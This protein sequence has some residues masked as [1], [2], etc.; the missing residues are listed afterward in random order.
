MQHPDTLRQAGWGITNDLTLVQALVKDDLGHRSAV[1]NELQRFELWATNLGLLHTGHS[2]LDYRLRDS[3]LVFDYALFLLVDLE[4]AIQQFHKSFGEYNRVS[5][6]QQDDASSLS[7]H[8]AELLSEEDSD[9]EDLSSYQTEPPTISFFRNI[10]ST[11]DKLYRLAFKIR[12]PALRFGFSKAVKYSQKD[13]ETGRDLIE[14]YATFDLRH[15]EEIFHSFGAGHHEGNQ[16]RYLI[17]RLAKANT[18]RR[19]QFLYWKKRRAR[20]EAFERPTLKE[21]VVSSTPEQPAE[22]GTESLPAKTIPSISKPSTATWLNPQKVDLDENAS[23]MSSSSTIF[24]ISKEQDGDQIIIPPAPTLDASVKEFECPFCF[25]VC[26]RKTTEKSSWDPQTRDCP[27]C[28]V[29]NV[30]PSH[31]AHHLRRIASFALPRLAGYEDDLDSGSQI[32]D[33]A[34]VDSDSTGGPSIGSLSSAEAN[35][36]SDEMNQGEPAEDDSLGDPG[37]GSVSSSRNANN[38]HLHGDEDQSDNQSQDDTAKYKL[39]MSYVDSDDPDQA[40]IL[41]EELVTT[42][43]KT[44]DKADP[45]RLK[46]EHQLGKIL[47]AAGNPQR[48]LDLLESVISTATTTLGEEHPDLLRY[49]HDLANTYLSTGEFAAGVKLSES[50]VAIEEKIYGEDHLAVLASKHELATIYQV[51]DEHKRGIELLSSVLTRL[52][53]QLGPDHPKVTNAM[54]DLASIY[55]GDGQNTKA[56]RLLEETVI[57]LDRSPDGLH[58]RMG[59]H[60]QLSERYRQDGQI[61]KMIALKERIVAVHEAG[62]AED[63]LRCLTALKDLAEAYRAQ[64]NMDKAKE[65][66]GRVI[67]IQKR[68]QHDGHPDLLKTQSILAQISQESGQAN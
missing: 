52:T 39:A 57:V 9:E 50:V 55:H 2:S 11:I 6:T 32:S 46:Y 15:I 31:V 58:S 17:E 47:S 1:A 7:V 14:E 64:G 30:G 27:I 16:H 22:L 40:L 65:L 34:R 10:V 43:S 35:E 66:L 62:H 48:A 59:A 18:R 20:Y 38:D 41:L 23:A 26:P 44:L 4:R 67:A 60:A 45:R 29:K 24:S 53:A 13:P 63:R 37:Q 28:L 21:A 68:T 49:K 33:G 61:S 19:Q 51:N 12:N 5:Q 36:S 25:T 42:A 56:M 54:C 3:K 8:D